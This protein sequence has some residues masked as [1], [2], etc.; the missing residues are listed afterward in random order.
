VIRAG[1]ELRHH[2][3]AGAARDWAETWS[4]EFFAADAG[5]AGLAT[6]SLVPARKAAEYW[7]VLVG[8]GRPLLVVRDGEAPVPAAPGLELRAPGLWADHT[9]ETPLEHWTIGLEAFAL[10]FDDPADAIGREMG[11]PVA[12]GFDLE[13]EAEEPAWDAPGGYRQPCVVSGDV[14]VGAERIVIEVSGFR[15]HRWGPGP[16]PAVVSGRLDDGTWFA[17]DDPDSP[18]GPFVAAGLDLVA[19]VR[20]PAPVLTEASGRPLPWYQAAVGVVARDGRT[21]AGWAGWADQRSAVT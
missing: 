16:P 5:L 21:G 7:A 4:F 14:L 6:L 12:L 18:P 1:D 17:A 13:W 10:A 8:D 2:P 9:C 20:H 19:A 15:S 11:D 3:G